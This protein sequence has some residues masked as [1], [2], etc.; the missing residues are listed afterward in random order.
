MS[1]KAVESTTLPDIE[2]L[3]AKKQRHPLQPTKYIFYTERDI[4]GHNIFYTYSIYTTVS[5]TCDSDLTWR[6]PM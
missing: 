3:V 5:S 1:G 4:I 2:Q 6:I